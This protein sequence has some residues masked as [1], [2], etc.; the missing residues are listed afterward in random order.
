MGDTETLSNGRGL[1]TE[2]T[3]RPNATWEPGQDPGPEKSHW[4]T[5]GGNPNAVRS[6]VNRSVATLLSWFDQPTR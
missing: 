6:L 5:S 4:G 3:R 1:E 2:E